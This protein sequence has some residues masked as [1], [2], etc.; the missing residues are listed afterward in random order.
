MRA[1]SNIIDR[2]FNSFE[3]LE[4]AITSA[5]ET[6]QSRNSVPTKVIE[7]LGSYDHIL[8]KQRR[9]AEEL[10]QY[11]DAEEWDEVTRRVSLINGLS[12]MIRDDA[13]SILSTLSLNTDHQDPEEVNFC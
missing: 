3:E 1:S 10:C 4:V 7:R 13:R 12:A 11:I 8:S 5:K 9:L 6:L 2:L